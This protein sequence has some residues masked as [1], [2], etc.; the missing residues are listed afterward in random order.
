MDQNFIDRL[1]SRPLHQRHLMLWIGSFLIFAIIFWLWVVQLKVR[2]A[3]MFESAGG[4]RIV[5]VVEEKQLASAPSFISGFFDNM[6][7]GAASAVSLFYQ[8]KQSTLEKN[9]PP[10][11]IKEGDELNTFLKYEPFPKE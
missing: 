5:K 8:K 3:G 11:K 2:I 6:K 9:A 1:R 7:N 4:R 10:A